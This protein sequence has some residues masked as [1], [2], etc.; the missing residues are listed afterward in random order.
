[1]LHLS[2]EPKGYPVRRGF[3][4]LS[5]ASLEYWIARSSQAMTAVNADATARSHHRLDAGQR[6]DEV[7]EFGAADFEIAILVERRAGRRQQHHGIS[8]P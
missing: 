2:R 6:G 4:V 7:A 3:T 8:Q 1:V 5:L